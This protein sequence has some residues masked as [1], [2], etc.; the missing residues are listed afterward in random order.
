MCFVIISR[1]STWKAVFFASADGEFVS[2]STIT[3]IEESVLTSS[4]LNVEVVEGST[5][6]YSS[7]LVEGSTTTTETTTTMRQE[8]L[9]SFTFEQ[10]V[11]VE[12]YS[13]MEAVIQAALI[14]T[15]EGR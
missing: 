11:S 12:Q 6:E 1:E 2:S 3:A 7:L 8:E 15:N 14:S 9:H 13:D 4:V 10:A 5:V